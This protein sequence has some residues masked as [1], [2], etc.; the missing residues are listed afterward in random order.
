MR[1]LYAIKCNTDEIFTDNAYYVICHPDDIQEIAFQMGDDLYDPDGSKFT[2]NCAKYLHGNCD[3]SAATGYAEFC[4]SMAI[5][6]TILRIE[7]DTDLN[8]I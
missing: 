4:R 2:N 7:E 6:V 8:N 1:N 5:N 3:F